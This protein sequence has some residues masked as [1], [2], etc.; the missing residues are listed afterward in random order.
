MMNKLKY[1][2][3]IE[4]CCVFLLILLWV[5]TATSKLSDFREFRWQMY[6]QV[7]AKEIARVLVYVVP[8]VELLAP[9]LLCFAFTRLA[10]LLLST[11]L[12]MAFSLYIGLALLNVYER[13]PCSCGGV[14]E[15][16]DWQAH[17]IFNLIFTVIAVTGTIFHFKRRRT[18]TAMKL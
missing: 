8:A 5:Y 11:G 2:P 16:L 10:G 17:F 13:M 15:I 14:L 1:A 9:I 18:V 7:F 4:T 3:L 6:N 12:M